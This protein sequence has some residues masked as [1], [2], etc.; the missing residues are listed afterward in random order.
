MSGPRLALP[1]RSASYIGSVTLAA[2][3]A[4]R[5]AALGQILLVAS[6]LGAST[7]ADLYFIASIAPLAIGTIVGEALFAVI[8]PPLVR[9]PDDRLRA[10]LVAA[11]FW[12]STAAVL[13]VTALYVLVAVVVVREAAPAGSESLWPWLAFAPLAP[14][15]A[16]SA[17][18]AAIL[19]ERER[20]F[21]PPFR[22]AVATVAALAFTAVALSRS[23]DVTWVGVAVTAGYAVS[24]VLL[25]VELVRTGGAEIFRMPTRAAIGVVAARRRKVAAS[26]AAGAI[27]G[28][29]FVLVERVLAASLGVGA[30]AA[31]SYARGL[32]FTPNV[33]GQAIALGV[34]PGMLRAHAAEATAHLR[35]TFVAGLRATLYT[36][37]VPALV[38]ALF[39]DEIARIVFGHGALE[40]SARLVEIQSSLRGF[41]P[42]VVG[43][44]TLI[45]TARVFGAI[46]FFRALV[47]SQATAL[48]AYLALAPVLRVDRGPGGLALAFSVAELLGATVGIGLA[49][50]RI[51]VPAFTLL[52]SVLAVV[53]WRAVAL[54]AALAGWKAVAPATEDVLRVG[55]ACVIAVVLGA[56][57]V[58]T[59]GWREVEGVRRILGRARR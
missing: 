38:L 58:W 37:V 24:V 59:T 39:A 56:A 28:Q 8:L 13:L 2:R 1:R 27:G 45:F 43:S 48:V 17:F 49:A 23:D 6:V 25:L 22:S 11:G 31:L 7:Q 42:A 10:Q 15:T 52:R 51:P 55:G 9:E 20:Y 14:L 32:S 36:A 26:L 18:L 44:L 40:G 3:V 29:A 50:R 54:A 46:D 33:V 19:L 47:W 57:L 41:A 53:A 21:A 5:L 34:Y 12:L 35:D 4:D 30:V 16:L